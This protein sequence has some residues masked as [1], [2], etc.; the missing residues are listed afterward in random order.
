MLGITAINAVSLVCF[1]LDPPTPV[2]PHIYTRIYTWRRSE[3]SPLCRF[4]SSPIASNRFGSEVSA[5]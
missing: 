2:R 5:N 1:A 3:I 4:H